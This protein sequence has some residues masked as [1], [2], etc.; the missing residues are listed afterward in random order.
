MK[1]YTLILCLAAAALLLAS[2]GGAEGGA[3]ESQNDTETSV[4]T[5]AETETETE[6]QTETET[7]AEPEFIKHDELNVTECTFDPATA[8]VTVRFDD[9]YV[10]YEADDPCEASLS[11]G[12][13]AYLLEGAIDMTASDAMKD[14]QGYY[15]GA[16]LK[17]VPEDTIDA[18]EYKMILQF[19]SYS[20]TTNITLD[21]AIG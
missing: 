12:G 15:T 10:I 5:S 11:G 18:G 19:S 21:S 16:V 9:P 1:K 3:G 2:C 4:E 14:D 13:A 6:A 20:V 8:T 17:L 7:T